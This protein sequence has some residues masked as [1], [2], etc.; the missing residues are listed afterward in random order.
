MPCA[1]GNLPLAPPDLIEPGVVS[2]LRWRPD[3][4]PAE[5]PAKLDAFGGVARKP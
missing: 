3:P 4:V 5:P 2:C 1:P